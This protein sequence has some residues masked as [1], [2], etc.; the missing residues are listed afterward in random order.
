VIQV[1]G[2]AVKYLVLELCVCH[3]RGNLCRQPSV[4]LKVAACSYGEKC[5]TLEEYGGAGTDLITFPRSLINTALLND[6]ILK[7]YRMNCEQLN[8]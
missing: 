6:T 5:V 8:C 7:F 2:M 4:E 1:P 3:F